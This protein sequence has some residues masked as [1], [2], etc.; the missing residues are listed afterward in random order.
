MFSSY[1]PGDS[2]FPDSEITNAKNFLNALH[3][4]FGSDVTYYR[5]NSRQKMIDTLKIIPKNSWVVNLSHG[6]PTGIMLGDTLMKWSELNRLMEQY[7]L[8]FDVFASDSCY[9][10]HATIAQTI[11]GSVTV[12]YGSSS[13]NGLSA[14]TGFGNDYFSQ[15]DG[16]LF[17]QLVKVIRAS[18]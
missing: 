10:S 18:S 14:L 1:N 6:L 12:E 3:S 17:N 2:A 11:L 15:T 4:E 13:Q 8:T 7:Q 5:T 9:A 16:Q